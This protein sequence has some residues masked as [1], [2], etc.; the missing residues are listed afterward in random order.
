V[1]FDNADEV[2]RDGVPLTLSY[3]RVGIVG[4]GYTLNL[5]ERELENILACRRDPEETT[6]LRSQPAEVPTEAV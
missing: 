4:A 5:R 3:L 1:R 2:R 6:V